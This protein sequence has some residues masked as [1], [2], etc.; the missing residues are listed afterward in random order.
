MARE[1]YQRLANLAVPTDYNIVSDGVQWE[2]RNKIEYSFADD[3]SGRPVFAFHERGQY[4][5]VMQ[6]EQCDLASAAINA[7]AK[8]VLAWIQK[9]NWKSALLKNLV[10]RSN[11]QGE[12]IAALFI[13][14]KSVVPEL[15][16]RDERWC[17]FA[18]YYSFPL[19]PAA[20]PTALL[21]NNGENF[22]IETVAGA[23]LRY[24]L[25]SFF[26]VN[27]SMFERAA[28]DIQKFIP[29]GSTVIDYYAGVGSIGLSLGQRADKLLI[30][31][32]NAEAVGYAEENVKQN[33]RA[34]AEVKLV[35]A[36]QAT[37]LLTSD[38][39]VIVDPPRAGLDKNFVAA[40]L[41]RRP[42]RLVYLSCDLATQARDLKALSSS[43]KPIFFGLYNFFPRT[44]H[45]EGLVVLDRVG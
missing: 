25:N 16:A 29:I 40:V 17:G 44:P 14:E 36:E 41:E 11:R 24:G 15:P 8:K 38:A 32:N 21:A 26:Q 9:N 34:N 1:T 20:V 42:Q 37:S 31:E 22:L 10:V 23:K 33:K 43:F 7:T 35:A 18:V 30:V 4:W 2:Y 19:T 12:T 39:T 13:N 27:V 45:I 28:A 6:F 3:A 5:Q